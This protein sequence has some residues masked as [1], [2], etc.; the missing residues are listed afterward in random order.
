MITGLGLDLA[1]LERIERLI[2]RQPKFIDRILTKKE[3]DKYQSL[4]PRRKIEYAAGRFAAKEA[5]SKAMGTGIGKEY[6]FM[7][8]EIINDGNGKPAVTMPVL[9]GYTVHIS[10]THTKDYAAAQVIIES[11]SS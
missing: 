9:P 8:I 6:S 2:K 4:A 7:D 1:E 11:S 10:I 3:I 5:F